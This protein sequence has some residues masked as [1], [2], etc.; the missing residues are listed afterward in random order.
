[1]GGG[2]ADSGTRPSTGN[3]EQ[4]GRTEAQSKHCSDTWKKKRCGDNTSGHS[5]RPPDEASNV[6]AELF[7]HGFGFV[8]GP[9]QENYGSFRYSLLP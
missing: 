5:S 8:F 7:R 1:M 9:S 6:R 4:R 3:S 2:R